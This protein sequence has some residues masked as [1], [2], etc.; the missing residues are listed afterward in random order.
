MKI[1]GLQQLNGRVVAQGFVAAAIAFAMKL[2]YSTSSVDDL[3]WILAPTTFLVELI[4]REKF[5]FESHAGYM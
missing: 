3:R 5:W 2:F 1:A 4:T